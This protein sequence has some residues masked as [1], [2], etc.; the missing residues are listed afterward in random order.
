M[1]KIK[2]LSKWKTHEAGTVLEVDETIKNSLTT[3][4][5]A[6]EWSEADEAE[7]VQ[8]AADLEAQQKSL[9][10]TVKNAVAAALK[11]IP[12]GNGINISV[13][14][15]E[16][17]NGP[18]KSIGEQLLA[19]KTMASDGVTSSEKETA[20]NMLEASAK[21]TKAATGSNELVDSEGGFLV[22]HD[23]MAQLDQRAVETGQ[24]AARVDNREVAGN[25]LKW[26]ELD[27][28]NRTKGNHPTQ[29]KWL[30]E[31]GTK[32]ASKPTFIRRNLELVKMCGLYYATDELLED[33]PALAG[34]VSSWFGDE[35]GFELDDAIYDG[36]GAGKPKG[37]MNSACL[38]SVGAESGQTADTVV[39]ENVVKM[40][41]RVPGRLLDG[42]VWIVNQDVLPQLPLMKIADQPVFLPPNGLIDAPAGMLLGKPIMISEHA[43]TI[44]DKGD[45]ML[46][47]LSQYK[48]IRKG[49]IKGASSIHVRFVNDE[50]AFRWVMRV[51]G[52]TK[53]SKQMT[54]KNGSNK[55]SPFVVLDAR[56]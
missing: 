56:A 1:F 35:F 50:T 41:A 38:V 7:R 12:N 53:W 15:N 48:M 51:N 3:A 10:A 25:G 44:G 11:D 36:S 46:A 8:K 14:Y 26:N 47:N 30:E 9:D 49:G 40:F 33:A 31:A 42:A 2:L 19:A 32:T 5:I 52:D 39:A 34:E 21:A 27:D 22:Q 45:I 29:V 13:D 18:F 6:K 20:G 16:P 37:I 43:K 4:E 28:Y 54:P 55:L 23:F 24:L 17:E